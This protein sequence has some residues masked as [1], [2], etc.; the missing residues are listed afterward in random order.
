MT[1]ADPSELATCASVEGLGASLVVRASARA[2]R[3]VVALV[4]EVGWVVAFLLMGFHFFGAISLPP[5]PGLQHS[6]RDGCRLAFL[7]STSLATVCDGRALPVT[8]LLAG[9]P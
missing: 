8:Q 7:C 1:L 9:F 2:V 3:R 6:A 5:R 4:G